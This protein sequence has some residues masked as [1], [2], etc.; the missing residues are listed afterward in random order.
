MRVVAGKPGLSTGF[1]SFQSQ[2]ATEQPAR[3]TSPLGLTEE[4]MRCQSAER[5]SVYFDF[6]VRME[7][8]GCAGVAGFLATSLYLFS[9]R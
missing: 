5:V 9:T 8:G 2:S 1:Q 6:D 3:T 4:V 7:T